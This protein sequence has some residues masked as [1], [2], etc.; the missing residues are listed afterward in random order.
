MLNVSRIATLIA[1]AALFAGT[2]RGHGLMT[3]PRPRG[4]LKTQRGVEPKVM[5]PAAPIDYCPHCQNAGGTGTVKKAGPWSK[6]DPMKTSRGGFGLCGDPVG[7]ND[8]MKKGKF[9]NPD[10]MPYVRKYKPGSVANFEFDATTNHN[11]YL[12]FYL[13]DVSKM[14]GEDIS[15]DGFAEH[16]HYLERSPNDSCESGKDKECGPIDPK[17]PGRW[18]LPCRNAGGDQGDQILGGSNGKMA[19]KIPDVEI[20]MGVVQMYWLTQNSCNDPD[21]F[22]ENYNYPKAWAG[23]PGD[24]G[25]VGG[26]PSHEKCGA[27]GFPEEF[28]NCADVQVTSGAGA[29]PSTTTTKTP[30]STTKS[31]K[32][33]SS[34][35]MSN[36]GESSTM[37][38]PSVT[39]AGPKSPGS[40]DGKTG[41]CVESWRS[42]KSGESCC[43][44]DYV[45]ASYWGSEPMCHPKGEGE[46]SPGNNNTDGPMSTTTSPPSANSAPYT[47]SEW[48]SGYSNN[49]GGY[50][51]NRGHSRRRSPGYYGR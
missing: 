18:V 33:D 21:G 14:A 48:N 19:Y 29:G 38:T 27:G 17:W 12:E 42:C 40:T 50:W 10:S 39:T 36:N 47:R 32:G 24:G 37:T 6:Y 51:G 25:S 28:W 23:C 9:A 8:H 41:T 5:D 13:C 7:G 1:L 34:T 44:K 46:S 11:G 16:C 49:D 45:C 3:D 31:S 20:E 35:T 26:K 2:S 22:M 15:Y 43:S 4:A 30:S